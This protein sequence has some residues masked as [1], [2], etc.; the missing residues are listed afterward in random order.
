MIITLPRYLG[1]INYVGMK[2]AS[3][4]WITDMNTHKTIESR[5]DIRG[6]SDPWLRDNRALPRYH[7]FDT[8]PL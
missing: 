2:L 8:L 1:R 3:R 5:K 7:L 4:T 6:K